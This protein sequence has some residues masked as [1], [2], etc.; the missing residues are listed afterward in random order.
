MSRARYHAAALLMA[1]A[2]GATLSGCGT[3]G[4][5]LPPSLNLPDRVA[6]VAAARTGNQVALT[7]TMPKR[8]T[9]KQLLKANVDAHVCR[10]EGEGRCAAVADLSFAPGAAGSFTESLTGELSA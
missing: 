1:A 8:N 2:L 4:T 6:D 10:K 9:E 7:W 5:P 3:P